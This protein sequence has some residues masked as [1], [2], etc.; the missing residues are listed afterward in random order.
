MTLLLAVEPGGAL[1]R[2][3]RA[4]RRCLKRA[5]DRRIRVVKYQGCPTAGLQDTVD[6]RERS[7]HKPLVIGDRF[8]APIVRQRSVHDGLLFGVREP[9]QPRLPYEVTIR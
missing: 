4:R 5:P 9:T 7:T 2:E 1:N 3:P 6:L 8:A